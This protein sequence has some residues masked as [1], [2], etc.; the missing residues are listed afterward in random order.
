MAWSA[1]IGFRASTC[2]TCDLFGKNGL[3]GVGLRN[4]FGF[5]RF[6]ALYFHLRFLCRLVG[7]SAS[8]RRAQL[9][10]LW[11]RKGCEGERRRRRGEEWKGGGR[12]GGV[13]CKCEDG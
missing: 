10:H 9:C 1:G 13:A 2:T 8:L 6:Q 4:D 11:P 5:L 12:E 7:S 3:L